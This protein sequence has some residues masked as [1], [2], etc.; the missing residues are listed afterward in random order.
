MTK[1]LPENDEQMANIIVGARSGH[2][3]NSSYHMSGKCKEIPEV[4]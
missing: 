1:R 3:K 2:P 4:I